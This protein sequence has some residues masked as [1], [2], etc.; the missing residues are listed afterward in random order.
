MIGI[1]DVD[2]V[3][4]YPGLTASPGSVFVEARL[5]MNDAGAGSGTGVSHW[6]AVDADGRELRILPRDP[7]NPPQGVLAPLAPATLP[8]LFFHGWLVVEAP[9]T[10]VSTASNSRA[11]PTPSRCSRT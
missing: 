7:A 8:D 2:Q 5:T 11:M 6:R 3:S 9:P 1:N 10:R 4:A